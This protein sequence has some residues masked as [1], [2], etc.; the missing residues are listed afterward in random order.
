MLDY[1][2]QCYKQLAD[3]AHARLGALQDVAARTPSIE[4]RHRGLLE[5]QPMPRCEPAQAPAG[6]SA[7][8]AREAVL[9]SQRQCYKQLEA[10][11][12][13]R[14]GALQDAL[15]QT[16]RTAPGRRVNDTRRL[17]N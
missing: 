17:T 2:Q 6:A 4:T 8:E 16:A 7:A 9:D 12:R 11:E 13:S 14:L 10:N 1:E 15:R 5:R 3:I